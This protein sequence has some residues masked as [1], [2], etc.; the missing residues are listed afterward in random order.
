MAN[1]CVSCGNQMLPICVERQPG[2][3]QVVSGLG[4]NVGLCVGVYS[5]ISNVSLPSSARKK[6]RDLMSLVGAVERGPDVLRL[7]VARL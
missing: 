7:W 3:A 2:R 4:M 5:G 1:S 6:K